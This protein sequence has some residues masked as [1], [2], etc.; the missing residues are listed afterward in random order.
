MFWRIEQ[1]N[2]RILQSGCRGYKL[3]EIAVM[4]PL[5]RINYD[6]DTSGTNTKEYRVENCAEIETVTRLS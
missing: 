2:W 3:N 6:V 4:R 1:V 5:R